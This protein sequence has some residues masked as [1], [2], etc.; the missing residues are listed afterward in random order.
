M[1]CMTKLDKERL[2][3]LAAE[4]RDFLAKSLQL[5]KVDFRIFG[6]LAEL[7]RDSRVK[8]IELDRDELCEGFHYDVEFSRTLGLEEF[9]DIVETYFGKNIQRGFGLDAD[10]WVD[11]YKDYAIMGIERKRNS[12][13]VRFAPIEGL[14]D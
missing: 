1:F 6:R 9:R 14:D 8:D 7:K 5:G 13:R 12:Y 11:V 2:E 10:R 3:A 4:G